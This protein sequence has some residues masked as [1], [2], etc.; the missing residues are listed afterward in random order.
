[1]SEITPQYI[2]GLIDQVGREKVFARA[3][4]L[5]WSGK[6]PPLWVW[7]QICLELMARPKDQGSQLC[8]HG[9]QTT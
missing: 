4:E 3:H 2:E 1:M 8:S 7:N 6:A 9:C 5:G